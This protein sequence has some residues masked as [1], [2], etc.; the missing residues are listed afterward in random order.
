M[1]VITKYSCP[2][3]WTCEGERIAI[4][5]RLHG[6][7]CEFVGKINKF[8][9]PTPETIKDNE[10]YICSRHGNVSTKRQKVN[11]GSILG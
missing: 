1:S 6:R 7:K 10:K 9:L 2:C 4:L 3:G 8:N 11:N 5:L